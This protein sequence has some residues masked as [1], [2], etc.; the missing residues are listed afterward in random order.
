V[1]VK[2]GHKA[3]DVADALLRETKLEVTFA[4]SLVALDEDRLPRWWSVRELVQQFLGLR[5]AAVIRRSEVRLAKVEEELLAARAL[6]AVAL[7]KERASRMILD[8]EDRPAAAAAI[9]AG[10]DLTE[11]QGAG[12]VALPLYRLTKADALAAQQKVA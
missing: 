6:A 11:E 7:D 12:I 1:S 5:D 4:A 10:F 9:A 3:E 2:R 8:A